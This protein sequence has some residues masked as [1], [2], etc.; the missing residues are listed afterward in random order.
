MH[1]NDFGYVKVDFVVRMLALIVLVSG[2]CYNFTWY[3]RK[4]V[5]NKMSGM[6]QANNRWV[7]KR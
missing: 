2:H 1:V 6:T 5:G 4:K 7:K 3:I